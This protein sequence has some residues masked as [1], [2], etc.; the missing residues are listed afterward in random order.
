MTKIIT[1]IAFFVC[2]LLSAQTQFEQGMGKSL[3]LWGEGK[4]QEASDL[5]ERIAAAEKTNWLPNYYVALINT[6]EA[7]KPANKA[8]AVALIEKAQKA[9]DEA[10]MISQNNPELLV[11]QAMIYTALIVQDPMVNGMKYSPKV[12]ELYTKAK[13]IAPE[14]PRAVYCKAEFEINSAPWTGADVKKLCQ[15]L[16]SAIPLFEK[17]KQETPFHPNW[18]LE[19]AQEALKNCK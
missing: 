4:A 1:T 13:L 5:M 14:N 9:Q 7:F 17:F 12:M 6:T 15:D 2:S 8:N 18:G 16:Q 10:S 19:R 11:M 3:G